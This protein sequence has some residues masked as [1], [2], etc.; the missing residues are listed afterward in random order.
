MFFLKK[1]LF[2]LI[3][4]LSGCTLGENLA[5]RYTREIPVPAHI[6]S[7][8]VCIAL[9]MQ[10]NETFFSAITYDVGTPL[11]QVIF[12]SDKQPKSGLFCILPEEFIFKPG[13]EYLTQIEVNTGAGGEDKKASRKAYVSTFRVTNTGGSFNIE[14]TVRKSNRLTSPF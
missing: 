11:E 7:S 12:P 8:D 9:P 6:R 1:L 5:H 3:V 10:P 13:H 14:Q 2:P 4:L